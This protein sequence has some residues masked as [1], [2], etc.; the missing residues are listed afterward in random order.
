MADSP[1]IYQ[2][3]NLAFSIC[4]ASKNLDFLDLS[5]APRQIPRLL[6]PQS[7]RRRY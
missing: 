5:G 3:T 1:R 2:Q 4:F 6:Y 7:E